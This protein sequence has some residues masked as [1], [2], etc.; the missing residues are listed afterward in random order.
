VPR[1][2]ASIVLRRGATGDAGPSVIQTAVS[3]VNPDL[4]ISDYTTME[5]ALAATLGPERILAQLTAVFALMAVVLAAVGLYAVLAQSV[6]T[7][8]VEI[9]IRLALGAAPPSIL[10]LI[11]QEAICLVAVGTSCGLCAAALASRL[12]AA[13][14]HGVSPYDPASYAG[15]ALTFAA[16]GVVS[17]LVPAWRATRVDPMVV[18]HG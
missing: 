17:A 6:A 7:R 9:G 13:Q 5:E 10:R 11:V 4:A 14:L 15:V 8:T 12:A 3:K 1:P 18:L 16:I 2:T